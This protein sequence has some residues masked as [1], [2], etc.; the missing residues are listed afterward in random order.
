M[1]SMFEMSVSWM[2]FH[3]RNNPIGNRINADAKAPV[4]VLMLPSL[5]SLTPVMSTIQ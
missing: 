4:A 1:L 5:A 2:A 3:V